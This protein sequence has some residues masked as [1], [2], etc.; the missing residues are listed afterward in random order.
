MP[1]EIQDY[2]IQLAAAQYIIDNQKNKLWKRVCFEIRTYGRLKRAWGHGHIMLRSASYLETGRYAVIMAPYRNHYWWL[3][4]NTSIDGAIANL[5]AR[6]MSGE[7]KD[8]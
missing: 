8:V 4:V 2:I 6:R 7:Y 5:C 1:P 3:G